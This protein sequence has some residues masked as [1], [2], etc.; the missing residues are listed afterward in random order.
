M[1]LIVLLHFEVRNMDY[2]FG[3][4]KKSLRGQII[5]F[6]EPRAKILK[7]GEIKKKAVVNINILIL[8]T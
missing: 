4:H 2:S 5:F 8:S 1:K 7:M 3:D 6:Y